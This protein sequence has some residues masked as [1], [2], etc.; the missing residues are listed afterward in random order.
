MRLALLLPLLLSPSEADAPEAVDAWAA[1]FSRGRAT[2]DEEDV[3]RL[4]SLLI[5]LRGYGRLSDAHRKRAGRSLLDLVGAGLSASRTP[6]RERASL[7][8]GLVQLGGAEFEGLANES[9]IDWATSEILVV[10]SGNPPARRAAAAHLVAGA[11]GPQVL[12]ALKICARD[13]DPDLKAAAYE[14][15]VGREDDGTHRLFLQTLW[16][17]DDST[18]NHLLGAA[19]AHFRVVR[20][21]T[22]S[23]QLQVLESFVRERI[24][25]VSWRRASRAA[26]VSRA[27]PDGK[28]IPLLIAGLNTWKSRSGGDSPSRRLQHDIARELNKRSGLD[29]GPH[30]VR[31]E[32]WW[33]AKLAGA[34][35]AGPQGPVL[36]SAGFFGLRPTSDRLVFVLDQSG[37]MGQAFP[38][39]E[40][41]TQAEWTRYEEAIDQMVR[42]LETLGPQARFNLVLF[43]DGAQQ[44]RREL[45]PASKAHLRAVAGWALRRPPQGGT[46]LRHGVEL[47]LGLELDG[48]LDLE[49]L[50]VDTLVVLCDGRT[51]EGQNWVLPVLRRVNPRARIVIHGVQIGDEGDGTLELLAQTTGGDFLEVKQTR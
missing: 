29:L 23:R 5:D 17:A 2:I 8:W 19:E 12:Q 36:T 50:E 21:P 16:K 7:G 9:L 33:Q 25:D 31:W 48:S 14:A 28:A 4:E 6:D 49:Q 42:F 46:Q 51:D 20:V 11:D 44:W 1:V 47:G 35:P 40:P 38:P 41:T 26:S 3:A 13:E 43:S 15:L 10:A 34:A 18:P 45:Q 22:D 24:G 27:L 39:T 37:S 32:T 30:P